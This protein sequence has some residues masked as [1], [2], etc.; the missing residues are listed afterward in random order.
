MLSHHRSTRAAAAE[1]MA[2]MAMRCC[3]E[4]ALVKFI[5]PVLFS[6]LHT[7]TV[8]H[9]DGISHEYFNVCSERINPT[10][11]FAIVCSH[12]TPTCRFLQLLCRL[13][14]FASSSKLA[15]PNVEQLL[16]KEVAWLRDARVS[17]SCYIEKKIIQT[18]ERKE[19][20]VYSIINYL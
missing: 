11:L 19:V 2:L 1:Q 6:V 12:L 18:L 8:T 10:S 16:M 13:L 17:Y 14:N 7:P 15:V 3:N 4:V 9:H 5:Q 20:L